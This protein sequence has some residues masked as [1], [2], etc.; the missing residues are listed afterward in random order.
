MS[1]ESCAAVSIKTLPLVSIV[2]PCREEADFIGPCL[3]SLLANDYPN[4]RLEVFVSDGMSQ[5]GTREIVLRYAQRFPF[6]KLLDNPQKIIPAGNNRAI[7]RAKGRLIM[8]AGAHAEYPPDYIS[9]CVAG[10]DAWPEADNVGGM[11]HTV[12]R[13]TSVLGKCI[14][15]ALSHPFAAGNA[16]YR[17]G[18]TEPRL[19]DTVWG[20][21]YRREVFK[22]I[23]LFNEALAATEDREL[24]ARLRDSGGKIMMLPGISC[25]YYQRTNLR[26][27]CRWMY[28]VGLWPFYGMRICGRKFI[29]LR[30]F[31]PLTFVIVFAAAVLAS[32]LLPMARLALLALVVAYSLFSLVAAWPLVKKEKDARFLVVSPLVFFLT[33]ILYGI[34]S[35]R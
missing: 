21:C 31:V 35:I 33:H 5:D 29:S 15:H 18:T 30:N 4:E 13:D 23:G 2:I 22:R 24:N 6:I 34:G 8:I 7:R 19:V 20:G 12:P 25:T 11:R 27:Y 9:K 14:A 3:D 26:D 28:R 16:V 32:I 17:T 1:L 10:M